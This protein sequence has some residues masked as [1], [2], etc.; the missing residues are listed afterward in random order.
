MIY[1]S[2]FSK[3]SR[4]LQNLPTSWDRKNVPQARV[5]HQTAADVAEVQF[6]DLKENGTKFNGN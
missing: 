6:F 4:Y 5:R 1:F 3:V 2:I